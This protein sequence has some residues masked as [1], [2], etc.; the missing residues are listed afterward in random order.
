MYDMKNLAKLKPPR[1]G[2]LVAIISRLKI[3][4][5]MHPDRF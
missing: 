3:P 4:M 1:N 5:K 2:T